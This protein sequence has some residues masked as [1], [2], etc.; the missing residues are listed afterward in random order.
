MIENVGVPRR[1][2]TDRGSCYTSKQFEDFCKELNVKHVLNATAT[3]RANV[4]VERYN[5]TILASLSTSIEDEE[6]WDF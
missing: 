5:Q 6:R 4:Q 3:Q 2:I 1:I